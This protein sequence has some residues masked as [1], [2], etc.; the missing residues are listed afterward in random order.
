MHDS[1]FYTEEDADVENLVLWLM[2]MVSRRT[3]VCVYIC[4]LYVY[5]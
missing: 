4:I 1:W 5:M 3:C 2:N